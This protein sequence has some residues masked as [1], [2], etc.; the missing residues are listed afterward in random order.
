MYMVLVG[1]GMPV[2]MHGQPDTGS[3][4]E[5]LLAEFSLRSGTLVQVIAK[6]KSY[7]STNAPNATSVEYDLHLALLQLLKIFAARE[8]F[9]DLMLPEV[10]TQPR[11]QPSLSCRRRRRQV[12]APAQSLTPAKTRTCLRSQATIEFSDFLHTFFT[13]DN[14]AKVGI[15]LMGTIHWAKGLQADDVYIIQPGSVPLAERIELGGWQR[16]EELCIQACKPLPIVHN[17]QL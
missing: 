6:L 14:E 3:R 5:E 16:W 2:Q 15:I 12:L 4:L 1:K 8:P 9:A 11:P 10:K 7:V 17:P 13:T